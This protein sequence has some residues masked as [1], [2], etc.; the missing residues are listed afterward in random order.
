M[1]LPSRLFLTGLALLLAGVAGADDDLNWVD[2]DTMTSLPPVQQRPIPVWCSGIYYN[3]SVGVPA[4]Q[5]DIIITADSTSLTEDGL[6]NMDG[7]VLIERPGR[8]LTTQSALLDQSSGKFE[9][10]NSLRLET[11]QFTFIADGMSGQTQRREASL[12][13]VRYA[14]FGPGARGTAEHIDLVDN[15]TTIEQGTYTTCAPGSNGWELGGRQIRLDREKGWGEARDVTL[16][17]KG[18]P[19]LWLPW[20][21]FPIDERRKTG[22]LFPTI[23]TSD[24]GGVD[25]TQPIYINIHPQMDAT[26]APRHIDGRG[27]GVEG[28]FRY[29]SDLG[30]GRL[31]YGVLFNDSEF[32]GENRELAAWQHDG[33]VGRWALTSDVNYVSDDFYFKDLDTGLEVSSRTHLPRLGQ[34][35]YF[36][37][38]WRALARLQSWQTIDPTLPDDQLPYR[39]L[40]QL[41]LSGD[42]ELLGPV[43]GLWL[44]DVTAFDR[45]DKDTSNNPTGARVHLAPGLAVRMEESWGYVEP[46]ARLY[47]NRYQ[48]DDAETSASDA[49]L[50]T[51][52]ASVDSGLFL[53]RETNLFGRGYT[54]T[55]EPRLFIN[56]LA[57]EQQDQ[58]P[59]FDSGE[60]TFS[61]NT[62]FR[63][64]RFIGYD[65]FGDEEKASLGLTSRFL[66]NA[67]G[68]E[69]LRLR[70]GQGFYRGERKVQLDGEPPDDA[71]QTPMVADMR[72][73]FGHDWYLYTEG[74][75][76]T[77]AN[78]RQR[79]SVR[80]GYTDRERRVFNLAFHDRPADDIRQSEIAT[81]LPIHNNWRLVG[82]W[83]YDYENQRTLETLAG[84]EWRNCCW[85]IRLLSQRE[86]TDEDG[87]T[88]LEADTTVL[89]QIQMTGLGGFGGRVDS[90]LERSI[91]GYRSEYD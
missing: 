19:L 87:D 2:R 84:A 77:H 60:L 36:G 29:L 68:R 80:L 49:T 63:Q 48:L 10:A 50:S 76:D 81:I 69:Q 75:W 43:R 45:S 32:D 8:R 40:P 25:L 27:S 54:Q 55:L 12:N 30:Q 37:R 35:R 21:T 34:A 24:S 47:H 73:N 53:E 52:G 67:D 28:E 26:I 71:D 61:Y 31:S 58:L 22:L 38:D 82:R 78:E 70:L 3:P 85:K 65:R 83:L 42:P 4:D 46:Q 51:W 41:Q 86:L 56:K 16:R 66:R 57:Y 14:L 17:V 39:R 88:T 64:N 33:S 62:L 15:F 5:S 23:S 91:P 74:Q 20:I 7:E 59:N 13:R 72:W 11:D 79:S 89:L 6:I 1:P 90:L 9:V 44:S 18:M